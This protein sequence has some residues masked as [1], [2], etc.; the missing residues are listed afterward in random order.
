MP[1]DRVPPN[2]LKKGNYRSSARRVGSIEIG[3]SNGLIL[4]RS[5]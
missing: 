5:F 2:A 1:V 4:C 3:K